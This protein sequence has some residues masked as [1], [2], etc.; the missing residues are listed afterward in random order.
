[1]RSA[2]GGCRVGDNRVVFMNSIRA[3]DSNVRKQD[4]NPF[5]ALTYRG[6]TCAPNARA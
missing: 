1:M 6:P 2:P 4:S 3:P 5:D